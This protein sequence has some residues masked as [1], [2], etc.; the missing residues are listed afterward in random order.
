[1][2]VGAGFLSRRRVKPPT[3]LASP[4]CPTSTYSS[5]CPTLNSSP[6]PCTGT[7]PPVSVDGPFVYPVTPSIPELLPIH[8][9][10]AI[11]LLLK[12]QSLM[13]LPHLQPF[14]VVSL[15]LGFSPSSLTRLIEALQ[16]WPSPAPRASSWATV[17]FIH[18]FS[19]H[20]LSALFL[21]LA[22]LEACRSSWARDRTQAAAATSDP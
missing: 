8:H 5:M 15:S 6:V 14:N 13:F 18:S 11:L 19:G 21:F 3:S 2:L 7:C 10:I 9:S 20:V 17:P 22:M 1:M 4:A 16:E 12:L